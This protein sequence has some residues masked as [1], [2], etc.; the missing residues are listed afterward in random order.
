[1]DYRELSRLG[2]DPPLIRSTATMIKKL[3]GA[4]MTEWQQ[5]FLSKLERFEGP[6][7]LSTRQCE[8]LIDLRNR[9]NRRS[10]VAGYQAA[11]LVRK[12][13][14]S[15][16]DLAEEDEEF[17]EKL[18]GMDSGIAL[19]DSEWKYV[20]GLCRQQHLIDDPYI[21]LR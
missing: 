4:G 1:M 11:V 9:V 18:H 7:R 3:L 13:W 21:P 16:L 8:T 10:K 2:G 17:V 5:E 20:F 15:R 14:E 19:S 12:L 6:D